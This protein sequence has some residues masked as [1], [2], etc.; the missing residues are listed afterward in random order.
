MSLRTDASFFSWLKCISLSPLLAWGW[1]AY[2]RLAFGT[3][4]CSVIREEAMSAVRNAFDRLS[5]EYRQVLED[6]YF[7]GLSTQQIANKLNK[8]PRTV[9]R[10]ISRALNKLR[11]MLG[12]LSRYKWLWPRLPGLIVDSVWHARLAACVFLEA[13]DH[14]SI[15]SW[16]PSGEVFSLRRYHSLDGH[17]V[18]DE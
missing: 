15:A 11:D 17:I 12:S 8:H 13:F 10:L 5:G 14:I 18:K 1:M 7:E 4:S 3:P 16:L 6:R 2:C 9:R